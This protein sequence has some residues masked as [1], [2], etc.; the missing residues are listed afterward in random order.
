MTDHQGMFAPSLRVVNRI[1]L[2]LHVV[3]D[4]STRK[5]NVV[6]STNQVCRNYVVLPVTRDQ[7]TMWGV[8]LQKQVGL[9]YMCH[10]RFLAILL[11]V[12]P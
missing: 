9:Y 7:K 11:K 2:L 12:V 3:C 8:G 4:V 10:L 6:F 5:L 1:A